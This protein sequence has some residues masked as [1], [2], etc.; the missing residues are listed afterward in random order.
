MGDHVKDAN[1]TTLFKDLSL[2]VLSR[3]SLC[4]KVL[5]DKIAYDGYS[6][7][8]DKVP[9]ER[10]TDILR[11]VVTA[12][13]K[14]HYKFMPWVGMPTS[15]SFLRIVDVPR[16]QGTHYDLNNL[17]EWEEVA[18]A[19]KA[20][21]IWTSL[22]ILYRD[23]CIN[24]ASVQRAPASPSAL[25]VGSGVIQSA[26]VTQPLPNA[27]VALV[28]TSW[29]SIALLQAAAKAI[30]RRTTHR[31]Q[32]LPGS[33][34]LTPLAA[35]T[36]ERIM[37]PMNN[38]HMAALL[39]AEEA[40]SLPP[41]IYVGGDF[42]IHS[43]EW[44]GGYHGRPGVAT[45]LL[46]TAAEL[47]LQR[48]PFVN[49]GPTFYP[50][51]QGFRSTVIDLVFVQLDQTLTAQVIWVHNAQGKSDHIP[52]A[53]TLSISADSGATPCRALKANREE[54]F[55][56]VRVIKGEFAMKVDKHAPLDTLDQIDV[57]A[58][59]IVDLFSAVWEICSREVT[60]TR[61]EAILK[62]GQN[63][64][65]VFFDSRITEI[66]ITNKRTWDCMT[67]VQQH[68]LPPCEAIQYQGQ[69]CHTLPQLWDTL[70]NTYNSASDRPFNINVLD[71]IPDMSVQGWVPF[72][73]LEMQ[74]ALASCSNVSAPAPDH[75]KWSH[76]KMLMHGPT[77]VFTVLLSLANACLQ[78][79]HWPKHFKESMLVIIPKLNKP[80]YS[81]PKA[82]RPIV[83]LNTVGKLIEKMLSN[84]IQFDGVASDVFHPN[85]IGGICQQSTED[86]GLILMHMVHAGWAKGLKTSIIAFDVA[87]FFLSL[88]HEV[89][90]AILR[91]LGFSDN[92]V[93]FF[94]HYLM[95]EW[96][97]GSALFPVLSALYL[98][99][100]MRLFKLDPLTCGCFLLSYV[101][102]G[103]FMVKSKSL[104]DNCEA[105]K[106]A[107]GVIFEL[108]KKFGLALEHDKS[109]VFH[110]DWSHS[111]D[112]PSVD[113]DYALYTGA[114]PLKPKLYWQ[115]L[116]YYF[117]RKLTF[118]EH[119]RYYSTKA[120]STVK[121]M[122]MLGSSIRVTY[123][124][125]LWYF[126]AAHC[127]GALH[128]LS[129]MQRSA[130]LLRL[131]EWRPSWASPLSIFFFAVYLITHL[132]L[133]TLI[134]HLSLLP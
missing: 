91:K 16:F 28:L 13:F 123:G 80:S 37:V 17:T 79:G 110:L 84:R 29:R 65:W 109:E 70:H 25:N 48:A 128:H 76:L 56:F 75:I 78:V 88:N 113:L 95:L 50:H 89:P 102:D 68:K 82:F 43:Q 87:Q 117:D 122:K 8:T 6:V 57:V 121:V 51:I 124:F 33:P 133:Q 47:G 106:R 4:V 119:V 1:L 85:Q 112:N 103:T 21:P 74:E 107:Y 126:A 60:I 131:V 111:K 81:A 100:I 93:R 59:A 63:A 42:N 96:G 69:P 116:G 19:L 36:A 125:R 71:F 26:A 11:G 127:K 114:T 10:D 20:S 52:L 129:T 2:D 92:V 5:G 61:L 12:H 83:L 55:C 27:R 134:A 67:W 41:F 73:A 7:P 99:L 105:L 90:M 40:A 118:T 35:Q 62:G 34:A 54:Q 14:A 58:Q 64:K 3:Q 66:S 15:K 77:H 9:S 108:F 72:S 53:T 23:P 98:T 97:Q 86:A 130:A 44:D 115:Y 24:T 132:G 22:H 39:L 30:Q 18:L 46:N 38:T 31:H 45:Q 101:D 94:S 104:L 120:L 49:P 32:C